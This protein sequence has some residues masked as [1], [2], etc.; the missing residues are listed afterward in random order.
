MYLQV[1]LCR[2]TPGASSEHLVR[3]VSTGLHLLQPRQGLPVLQI[4]PGV[5]ALKRISNT[6]FCND[7][8]YEKL[9]VIDISLDK[10]R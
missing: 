1:E 6:F 9:Y 8:N 3:A 10:F 2:G 4:V 5:H 7:L